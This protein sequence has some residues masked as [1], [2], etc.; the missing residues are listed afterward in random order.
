LSLLPNSEAKLKLNI[1]GANTDIIKFFVDRKYRDLGYYQ[2]SERIKL[3]ISTQQISS[4]VLAKY[5]QASLELVRHR[6]DSKEPVRR[7]WGDEVSDYIHDWI[8]TTLTFD[9]IYPSPEITV[10]P[11]KE[12][13]LPHFRIKAPSNFGTKL[14]WSSINSGQRSVN[15]TLAPDQIQGNSYLQP[16]NW[17][18]TRGD[19]PALNILELYDYNDKDLIT[20][21]QSLIIELKNGIESNENLLAL[22]YDNETK[23]YFTVGSSFGSKQI[24]I[25]TLPDE[26]I[27]QRSFAGSIKIYF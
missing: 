24:K 14:A 26:S 15:S 20:P 16:L 18:Q 21:D 25:H 11:G 10:T 1:N 6:G 5:Q 8:T 3:I 4:S 22:A 23:K 9:I 19:T 27:S 17:S 12:V 2:I 7:G 13:D